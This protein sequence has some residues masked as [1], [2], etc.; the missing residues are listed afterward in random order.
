MNPKRPVEPLRKLKDIDNIKKIL[1]NGKSYRNYCVF[2]CGINWALRASDLLAIKLGDVRDLK[3]G[4]TK[5]ITERK[6]IAN[7]FSSL[8]KVRR[9]LSEA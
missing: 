1:K 8:K 7:L 4:Q 6:T 5:A 9:L 3:V 2:I